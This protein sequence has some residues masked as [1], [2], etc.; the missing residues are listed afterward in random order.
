[1]PA[2]DVND[3]M[4]RQ[5]RDASNL[6][7]RAQLHARFSTH[8]LGYLHW[9]FERLAL[10]AHARVLELGCGPG[11]LW[12][13]NRERIPPGW[14]LTLTDLSPG[15]LDEARANLSVL[16]R[17]PRLQCVSAEALPFVDSS[18]DAVLAHHMLDHVPD[19]ASS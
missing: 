10:P 1:M 11:W 4:T 7:A 9:S 5:Y 8:R 2:D 16:A 17:P 15:M 12:R 14:S 19:H 3:L 18:F 13:D 6:G